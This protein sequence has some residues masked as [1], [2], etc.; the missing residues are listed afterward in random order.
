M[1]RHKALLPLNGTPIIV[2]HTRTLLS[3]CPRVIVVLGSEAERIVP[4]LPAG[5]DVIVNPNWAQSHMSDS[6][7]LALSQTSGTVIV[8]PVDVPPARKELLDALLASTLPAVPHFN[9]VP[10]HPVAFDAPRILSRLQ[11]GHLQ[12]ALEHSN[13]VHTKC[14]DCIRSWN[15]PEEW[16]AWTQ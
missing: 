13:A 15:T 1:G 2:A 4:E 9:S 5:T 11:E 6:L 3:V 7:Q 12:Q 14:A 16:T 10:G 8:T